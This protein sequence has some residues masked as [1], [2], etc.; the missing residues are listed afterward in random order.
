MSGKMEGRRLAS[1]DF[2][3]PGEPMSRIL[4]PPAAAIS[5]AR[6]TFSCPMTSAKSGSAFRAAC[7]GVHAGAGDSGSLPCKWAMSCS[8][9]STAYTVRPCASVASAA[10]SAGT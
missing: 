4:C 10:F 2:P 9:F 1:M 8:T 5:S 7:S 6:F 3:E